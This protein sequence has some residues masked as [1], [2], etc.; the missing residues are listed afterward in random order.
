MSLEE[1]KDWFAKTM[2]RIFRSTLRS[3]EDEI[4]RCEEELSTLKPGSK[5]YKDVKEDYESLLAQRTKLLSETSVKE[6]VALIGVIGGAAGWMLYRVFIE[7]TTDPFFSK[8]AETIF[9]DG[10]KWVGK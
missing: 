8:I 5:A 2:K 7:H 9:K 10:E 3:L 1:V 4:E 6:K